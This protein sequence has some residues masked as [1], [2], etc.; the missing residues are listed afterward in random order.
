MEFCSDG[1]WKAEPALLEE[2]SIHLESLDAIIVAF[3]CL[4]SIDQVA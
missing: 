2:F 4:E 1:T 3:V